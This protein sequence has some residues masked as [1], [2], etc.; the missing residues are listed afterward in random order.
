[1]ILQFTHIEIQ[2][3]IYVQYIIIY[4][5]F[6][7]TIETKLYIY[8]YF[9]HTH[10]RARTRAIIDIHKIFLNLLKTH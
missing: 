9:T 10:T 8:R 1:L 7:V 4:R 3:F 2:N 6:L 5:K